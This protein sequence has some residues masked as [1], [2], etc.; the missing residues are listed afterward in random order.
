[1]AGA[2]TSELDAEL[3]R[4]CDTNT[5]VIG[6]VVVNSQ[7]IPV[8]YSDSI[9]GDRAVMYSALLTNFAASCKKCLKELMTASDPEFQHV[10]LRTKLG[11]EIVVMPSAPTGDCT[12]IVLQNCTGR[13]W[14]EVTG[15]AV[16]EKKPGQM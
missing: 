11:S 12:M 16:E 10:R 15:H 13:P 4:F 9:S 5:S 2:Q 3:K 7:G 1:M 6:F 8:K 14:D